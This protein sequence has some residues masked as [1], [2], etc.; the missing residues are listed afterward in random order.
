MI[1]IDGS[2]NTTNPVDAVIEGGKGLVLPS[3]D[4]EITSSSL[5]VTE[6]PSVEVTLIGQENSEE[7]EVNCTINFLLILDRISQ[8]RF[9]SSV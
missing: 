1:H 2:T 6:R 4:E 5:S 7:T 3:L 8:L 9:L